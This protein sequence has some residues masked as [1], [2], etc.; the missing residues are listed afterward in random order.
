MEDKF[1]M[2]DHS[3][4][5]LESLLNEWEEK[6]ELEFIPVLNLQMTVRS[7]QVEVRK[8]RTEWTVEMAKDLVIIDHMG[9]LK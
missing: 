1:F 2:K 3:Q 4:S 6:Q 8:L 5:C 7:I 9:L